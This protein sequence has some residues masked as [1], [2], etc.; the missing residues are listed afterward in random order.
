MKVALSTPQGFSSLY[1][2]ITQSRLKWVFPFALFAVCYTVYRLWP[3][4]V[5]RDPSPKNPSES[6]PENPVSIDG[7]FN[8]EGLTSIYGFNPPEGSVL[9]T[10]GNPE[11]LWHVY[12]LSNWSYE[13]SMTL[14]C[15][16]DLT[17]CYGRT[18]S[19]H[20][21]MM[22]E[23][24]NLYN[25]AI[26]LRDRMCVLKD[27]QF[28]KYYITVRDI[29][30]PWNESGLKIGLL[31]K[32]EVEGLT[33]EEIL[34]MSSR[35]QCVLLKKVYYDKVKIAA[36]HA[37][38]D[39]QLKGCV[40]QMSA[41]VLRLFP[42]EL[43]I[44]LDLLSLSDDHFKVVCEEVP[45]EKLLLQLD[46][47]SLSDS[48]FIMVCAKV[49]VPQIPMA[50]FDRIARL[51]PYYLSELSPEQVKSLNFGENGPITRDILSKIAGSSGK[52]I[53]CL[54]P[55]QVRDGL[56][57]G[58]FEPNTAEW[59]TADQVREIDFNEVHKLEKDVIWRL[60]YDKNKVPS[61]Q[62]KS[63][64]LLVPHIIPACL[65]KMREAQIQVLDFKNPQIVTPDV[66]IRI[67]NQIKL[68]TTQQIMDGLS[69]GTL[70]IDVASN[71]TAE[72]LAQVDFRQ[73]KNLESA[74]KAG[75]LM[76]LFDVENKVPSIQHDSINLV[77]P[78]ICGM[79]LRCLTELQVQRLDFTKRE[80][81]TSK[82]QE[83]MCQPCIALKTY[84]G[85]LVRFLTP[86]QIQDGL[87]HGTLSGVTAR[88]VKGDQI[89]QI[90]FKAVP[91][92]VQKQFIIDNLFYKKNKVAR[93]QVNSL[94][95]ILPHIPPGCL[96]YL[97]PEQVSVI[98][99]DKELDVRRFE[100]MLR[101][102]NLK[103]KRP[104]G[105]IVQLMSSTQII[106]AINRNFFNGNFIDFIQDSQLEDLDLTLI[107][108]PIIMKDLE[109]RKQKLN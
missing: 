12:S 32:E 59:I 68:L 69:Y 2:Q 105:Y 39:V 81:V 94:R 76:R 34:K 25:K 79:N 29:E 48:Q 20:D 101:Y 23:R 55:E 8:G 78:H 38:T 80:C 53:R 16:R 77:V 17:I 71:V 14:K 58:C 44:Q 40:S 66:A 56:M 104:Q 74:V 5:Q 47:R 3:S 109:K 22:V 10:D 64:N 42:S 37:M 49:R 1:T 95:V 86:K 28:F 65:E 100:K 88:Y 13:Y 50:F 51:L 72:Q 33:L 41:A 82:I 67:A 27:C 9:H 18:P 60:F 61:I 30:L 87:E 63:V 35:Q 103:P 21:R 106:S 43:L 57:R 70:T 107:Q 91:D 96:R 84:R 102:C 99:F 26:R 83:G 19:D 73:V 46:L 108:I 45:S 36:I 31:N 11:N 6:L 90:D 89:A 52:L 97:T 15:V 85:A 75:V 4:R 92:L 93:I 7:G 98:D 24:L 62:L 54:A